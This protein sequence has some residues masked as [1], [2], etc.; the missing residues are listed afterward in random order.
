M[1]RWRQ[2][3][4]KNALPGVQSVEDKRHLIRWWIHTDGNP[5]PIAPSFAPRGSVAE[6][7]GFRVPAGSKLR[8]PFHPY[9]RHDGEGMSPY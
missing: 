6:D 8:L 4:S 1:Y 3:L 9:S 7:G 5:R 2:N